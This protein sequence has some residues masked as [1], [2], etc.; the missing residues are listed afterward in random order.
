MSFP[1]KL[2]ETAFCSAMWVPRTTCANDT[3]HR[4]FRT[5]AASL[6]SDKPKYSASLNERPAFPAMNSP[7]EPTNTV[8]RGLGES[9]YTL[10]KD[11]PCKAPEFTPAVCGGYI[12]QGLAN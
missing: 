1:Q 3:T 9:N 8:P 4:A 12:G 7:H 11:I 5:I 2:A 6:I 10:G